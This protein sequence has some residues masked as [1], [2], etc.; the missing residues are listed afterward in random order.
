MTPEQKRLQA[1]VAKIFLD[2]GFVTP[3]SEKV[4]A[5]FSEAA[6]KEIANILQAMTELGELL[7][8]HDGAGQPVIFH[9]DNVERAE[10]MLVDI[11]EKNSEIRLSEFREMLGSTR[12]YTLPLLSYFDKKGITERVGDV[13][14]LKQ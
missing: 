8:L 3:S 5:Q 4:I 14:R 1:A 11:L 6:P 12:K 2:S 13:R 7:E 9:S 10:R